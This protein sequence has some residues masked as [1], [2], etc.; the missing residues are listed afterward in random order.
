MRTKKRQISF[1]N[2]IFYQVL[3]IYGMKSLNKTPGIK[4]NKES[5]SLKGNHQETNIGLL[6]T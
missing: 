3:G 4:N 6:L 5:F 1:L 2:V